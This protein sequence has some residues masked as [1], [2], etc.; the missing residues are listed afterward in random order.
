[1]IAPNVLIIAGDGINCMRETAWAFDLAGARSKIVHINDILANPFMVDD[2]HSIAFP[3]GFSFGDE[4]GSGQLLATKMKNQ[5]RSSLDKAIERKLPIIGIC[6]GL[7][8]L[9]KLGLLPDWK[10]ERTVAM[11]QNNHRK[12]IDRWVT[13]TIEKN[14]S[15]WTKGLEGKT[16]EVP[17]RH[18]EGRFTFPEGRESEIYGKLLGNGQVVFKYTEDI[19]GSYEKIAGICDPNGVIL[20]LMPHPEAALY[21][22]THPFGFSSAPKETLSLTLF[23]NAVHYMSNL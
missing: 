23:K 13:L 16:L 6:N 19:N 22:T 18:G 1:M 5:L 20:G 11:A 17:V 3:G 10:G 15:I 7:Q 8:V 14:K 12:F 21:S 2:F 9:T 4:L